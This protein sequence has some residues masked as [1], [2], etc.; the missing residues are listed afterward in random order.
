MMCEDRIL[1]QYQR[2]VFSCLTAGSDKQKAIGRFFHP[3]VLTQ[4]DAANPYDGVPFTVFTSFLLRDIIE[5]N[6]METFSR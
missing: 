5:F 3:M 1:G 2:P 4:Y 6:W